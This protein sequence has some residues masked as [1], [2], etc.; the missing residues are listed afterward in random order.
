[1]VAAIHQVHSP[2]FYSVDALS[3]ST[4]LRLSEEISP[5]VRVHRYK[6]HLVIYD[7]G[8]GNE[9]TILRV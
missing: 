1:M 5:P 7:L 2:R 6:F 4:V 3:R 9:V 8:G